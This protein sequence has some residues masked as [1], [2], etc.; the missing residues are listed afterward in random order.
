MRE[1]LE[2]IGS[3]RERWKDLSYEEAYDA[4]K[5]IINGKATDIQTGAFWSFM[6]LKQATV[7][8]LNGFLDS[9]KEET[10]F[11]DTDEIKPLDL[12]V[13]Y[14]GKN[15]SIHILPASIFI[16]AGAG[17]KIVGHGN[18]KVPSKFGFTYQEVL[19][20]MGCNTELSN[21][22]ILR[23]LELSGFA[24]YHQKKLNPKLSSLL[25][26]R[27]EFYLRTYLNTVEKLLNPF[28]TY[29]VLIGTAHSNFISKYMEVAAYSGFKNIFVVKGLEGGIEPYPDRETKV[30]TNRIFSLSI[31][32]LSKDID[33]KKEISLIEN[34]E[35][36]LSVLKNEENPFKDWALLTAALIISA[37]EVEG[38]IKKSIEKAEESLGSGIA[39]EYF[40]VFK[41]LSNV[42][43]T[44]F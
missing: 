8:E 28:R 42:G 4:N 36:C 18:E 19:N 15:K 12:A 3:S 11:I 14:D 44:I 1:Y 35:I 13:G 29:N 40:E 7:E 21:D 30:Y 31:K 34:A 16:A 27:Q 39:L 38:D 2:K 32:S 10:N 24:F 17:A 5:R 37:Y 23:S 25:P 9:L 43:K 6:R 26:K 41:S 20:A 22:E 33:Y